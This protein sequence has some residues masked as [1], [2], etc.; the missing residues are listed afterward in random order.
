MPVSFDESFDYLS[1]VGLDVGQARV[2]GTAGLAEVL[3]R[4]RKEWTS[5]AINPLYQQQARANLE[6]AKQFEALLKEP[7]AA[8]AWMQFAE[9]QQ[10]VARQQKQAE[11][12]PLILFAA[13]SSLTLT[14]T[15]R[16]L[17]VKSG[18]Q[19]GL[20]ESVVDQMI[21]QASLP[22]VPTP[23]AATGPTLP[24][25]QPAME[26]ALFQQIQAQLQIL[27]RGSFYELLEVVQSTSPARLVAIA[28]PLHAKWGRMLPKTAEVTAWEKS[29]QSC[30]TYLKSVDLKER[31]D[32]A[33]ANARID[34]FL[35]RVDLQLARGEITRE[36]WTQLVTL[37][38]EQFGLA[39][40]VSERCVRARS[41]SRGLLP[42]ANISVTVQLA[43]Q[44]LCG[45]CHRYSNPKST[46]CT[47]CG[48][49]LK[50]RCQ[51]PK[52]GAVLPADAKVCP[53][54]HL[55]TA[56]GG[57]YRALWT[58]AESLLDA[59]LAAPALDAI[60]SLERLAPG[61]GLA[62]M[63]ARATQQRVLAAEIREAAAAKKWTA[64]RERLPE[65][66]R[67]APRMAIAGV[68]SLED[69][70]RFITQARERIQRLTEAAPVV[71]IKGLLEIA[72]QWQDDRDLEAAILATLDELE[73][74]GESEAAI[75]ACVELTRKQPGRGGWTQRLA[76]LR[77]AGL[78]GAGGNAN[79]LKRHGV[80]PPGEVHESR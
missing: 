38:V 72:V 58:L 63:T 41:V 23:A 18:G 15:Q 39:A 28:Q 19:R 9:Q 32:R 61:D 1:L 76:K 29:L 31:Y 60:A 8:T 47:H 56:R 26:P 20:P 66:L 27:G 69:V 16:E 74:T 3:K 77:G 59:G 7:G 71:R 21:Q 52:C 4:K 46:G 45:R 67:L 14:T 12:L 42:G 68:P 43:G 40:D 79:P 2:M 53:T 36:V 10:L 75:D 24:Y 57:Q 44:V 5:Q 37:G 30:L 17:L 70:T 6:R 49:G 62:A 13:G 33:L 65:L 64:A 55:A 51:H 73:A 50:V 25:E 35:E 80:W 48:A 54:C 34:R 22:I 11:F 78:A